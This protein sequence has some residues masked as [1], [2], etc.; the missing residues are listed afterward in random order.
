[1]KRTLSFTCFLCFKAL[2][3]NLSYPQS[4]LFQ[5][6]TYQDNLLKTYHSYAQHKVR[7]QSI[8]DK[9][10]LKLPKFKIRKIRK[11]QKLIRQADKAE[12]LLKQTKKQQVKATLT[13]KKDSRIWDKSQI[14]YEQESNLINLN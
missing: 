9:A 8:F 2:A 1:M 12:I 7:Q 4:H 11:S 5:N 6:P 3:N 10:P 14:P 13:N